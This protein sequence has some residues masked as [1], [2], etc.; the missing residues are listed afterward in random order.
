MNPKLKPAY[1]LSL[2]I[3]VLVLAATTGGL[4]ISG[5]YR[6]NALITTG[7]LWNDLITLV[8]ALPVL[9]GALFHSIRGSQR[10]QLVWL[11]MLYYTIYNYAFYLFGAVLNRFFLIYAA[12]FT[13]SAFAL[14]YGLSSADLDGIG[15]K[16]RDGIY[17]KGVS[18]YMMFM[19]LGL[20]SVWVGQMVGFAVT[21]H[22]PPSPLGEGGLKLVA[23]L[24][25][26]FQV[27]GMALAAIWLWR[28][29]P[30]GYGLSTVLNLQGGLYSVLLTVQTLAQM[31]AG[32]EG[33]ETLLPLWIFFGAASLISGAVL[34]WNLQVTA[35]SGKS[36]KV[37][38]EVSTRR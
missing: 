29:K 6:D 14:I 34:L 31:K 5:L 30:W 38:G 19:A 3:S 18:V 33:A 32:V 1:L 28:R 35:K 23:S 26:S 2:I 9:A 20:G 12:L 13:L 36:P 16:F 25:L 4:F 8:I 22:L 7:W 21:G 15:R 24:D 10:A 17:A 27:P 37:P 11:G